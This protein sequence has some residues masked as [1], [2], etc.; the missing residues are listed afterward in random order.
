VN[1]IDAQ[2]RTK[3]CP[4]ENPE[5]W[6]VHRVPPRTAESLAI[7]QG[8]TSC[9][10]Q[11][12]LLASPPPCRSPDNAGRT[13]PERSACDWPYR[14]TAEPSYPGLTAH[15]D[16]SRPETDQELV[17]RIETLRASPRPDRRV[18][19]H[20]PACATLILQWIDGKG[21]L[22]GSGSCLAAPAG[23]LRS[24]AGQTRCLQI[25]LLPHRVS[26]D[27]LNSVRACGSRRRRSARSGVWRPPLCGPVRSRLPAA[28]C[29]ARPG[30]SSCAPL[31]LWLADR[32]AAKRRP[33]GAMTT[34]SRVFSLA[35]PASGT[36][37]SA[38][39]ADRAR[40]QDRGE[41][42]TVWNVPQ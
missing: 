26:R 23:Q 37:S 17:Q 18:P 4:K 6:Q 35:P 11:L 16:K 34:R 28:T 40:R 7:S 10:S 32:R 22:K 5:V 29:A 1:Q 20:R 15:D 2:P 31:R 9:V 12:P 30:S 33:L 21:E 38:G 3:Q 13:A 8:H 39:E 42:G 14:F 19:R 27:A 41:P 36:S 25:T 24:A